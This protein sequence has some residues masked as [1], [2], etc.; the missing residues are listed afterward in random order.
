MTKLNNKKIKY[1]INQVTK[2]NQNTKTMAEIYD[3]TRRRVQQLVKEYRKTGDVPK[4]RKNRR[5]RTYLTKEEKEMID[6]VWNET[7]RGARLLYHELRMRGY[8]IPHNKI[9][10]YLKQT[11]RTRPNPRKQKKRKRCR[12]E[13]EHSGSLLHGDWHRTTENHPY[14]IVWLDDASRK[15]LSGGEFAKA[16]AEYSIE[17]FRK[18]QSEA[19]GYNVEIREVNTDRGTQFFSNKKEGTSLFQ[20]YLKSQDIKHIPSRVHNPQTNGKIERFWYE[21]DKH[22]WRFDSLN[23]FI[24]WYNDLIHGALW[25]EIGET[26]KKAFERK[27]PPE[28]ILGL[29]WKMDGDHNGSARLK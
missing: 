15:I 28:S 29:F 18:A 23:E 3:I 25:I 14:V 16:T 4:L 26:P 13:R 20:K 11:G 1:I 9:H 6:K 19:L 17:T 22:R 5:P 2:K 8:K 7:K 24:D 12:Y 21:Y 10:Q 27:M